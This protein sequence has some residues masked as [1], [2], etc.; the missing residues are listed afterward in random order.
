MAKVAKV[1]LA[2][3]RIARFE[4]PDDATPE[5]IT[6]A[7]AALPPKEAGTIEKTLGGA[8]KGVA[9]VWDNAADYLAGAFGQDA[10]PDAQRM[11]EDLPSNEG[12]R[13]I[14][15]IGGTALA[16]AATGGGPLMQGAI[17]G[18]LLSDEKG[19]GVFKDM[20]IGAAA[21]KAGDLV[22]KGLSKA[23]K[24]AVDKGAK[25]LDDLGI[26]MT[27]GQAVPGLKS[28]EDKLTSWPF[29]GGA[30]EKGRERSV[31]AFNRK[32]VD[33]SLAPV[34]LKLPEH[35]KTGREAVKWAGDEL[36]ARYTKILPK[37]ALAADDDLA[38]DIAQV[39]ARTLGSGELSPAA[40]KKFNGIVQN[41]IVGRVGKT[42]TG[43]QYRA[44]DENLGALIRRYGASSNPEDQVM[45]EGFKSIQY[46]M[47]KA[48]ERQNPAARTELRA[49]NQ[50][51]ASL[52]PVEGAAATAKG[53][54]FSP[55]QFRTAVRA[56]NK[57][58]RKRGVARGEAI[59]QKLS[60]TASDILPAS[61]GN[62]RSADR[63]LMSPARPEYWG[64]LA[65]SPLYGE[66][67]QGALT[68]M[69]VY[70]RGPKAEV[71]ARGLKRLPSGA[72]VPPLLL[73][74]SSD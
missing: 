56:A 27:I 4:V 45:A 43:Q 17:S 38:D 18:A 28:A 49:L 44:I 30:I 55:E 68:K 60:D 37:L 9:K 14:G 71:I 13:L 42:A 11:T 24:P 70:P 59:Q 51:W 15:E 63:L 67:A 40:I 46:A 32:A 34:G 12:G 53:G 72:L 36:G 21:S 7:A 26:P 58:V 20:A 19:A 62:S 54:V 64:G 22:L 66:K 52:V 31:N 65:L 61:M 8:A 33:A 29:V 69:F 39:G 57:T 48:L 25:F 74:G 1:R 5:Q 50:G 6:A 35:I 10:P 23:V 41:Q 73:G 3:G 2:D 16:T 47:S